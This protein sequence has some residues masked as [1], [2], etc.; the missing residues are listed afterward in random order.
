MNQLKAVLNWCKNNPVILGCGVFIVVCLLSLIWPYA[1]KAGAFRAQMSGRGSELSSIGSLQN[2]TMTIP[3]PQSDEPPVEPKGVITEPKIAKLQ[4]I[5]KRIETESKG[6]SQLMIEINRRGHEPMLKNLFP[7]PPNEGVRFAARA[8]YANAIKKLYD[9]LDAA[10]APGQE[11]QAE[12]E[13]EAQEEFKRLQVGGPTT[14]A[15]EQQSELNR[16]I[17]ERL[18]RRFKNVAADHHIYTMEPVDFTVVAA[19]VKDPRPGPF[20]ADPWITSET[21]ASLSELWESQMQLWV[22]QDIVEAIKIANR[23]EE[24]VSLTA[25]PIKR[26]E[27]IVVDPGFV[28]KEDSGR[29]SGGSPF[30]GSS[31]SSEPSGISEEELNKSLISPIPHDFEKSL[32]GR[33]SNNVYYVKHA[34]VTLVADLRQVPAIF[35]AINRVNFTTVLGM[36]FSDVDEYEDFR[37]GYYYGNG[38]DAVR[39]VLRLES[40]WFREWLAGHSSKDAAE[41]KGEPYDDGLMPDVI[42]EQVGLPKRSSASTEN[43]RGVSSGG[44]GGGSRS[45]GA[46]PGGFGP[47]P[48]PGAP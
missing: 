15:G 12:I 19:T 2:V 18:Q 13:Q 31:G 40:L 29:G 14:L 35:N 7:T 11:E 32:T 45:P 1:P 23:M 21:K 33:T 3:S 47:G 27:S 34:T 9:E 39:M 16:T 22:E 24:K 43:E 5:Y 28:G 38:V 6:L 41:K 4:G 37:N 46:F 20:M 48:G 42:R 25:M 10:Q 36:T 26:L 17:A 44:G 8:A 30:G